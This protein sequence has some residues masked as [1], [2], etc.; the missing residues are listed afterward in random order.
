MKPPY[1]HAEHGEG[2]YAKCMARMNTSVMGPT[3]LYDVDYKENLGYHFICVACD[4]VVQDEYS[5]HI[6]SRNRKQH[7]RW[8]EQVAGSYKH[9]R[10][11]QHL[12]EN[13]MEVHTM[14]PK[15]IDDARLWKRDFH[16]DEIV[17]CKVCKLSMQAEDIDKHVQSASHLANRKTKGPEIV[18]RLWYDNGYECTCRMMNRPHLEFLHDAIPAQ[19]QT[20]NV[21]S[22]FDTDDEDEMKK[23]E[24]LADT[25]RTIQNNKNR[26]GPRSTIA[27][28][29][30]R[31]VFEGV[32]VRGGA[33]RF[34]VCIVSGPVCPLRSPLSNIY[35]VL[36]RH[37]SV[38][39]ISSVVIGIT[40][41]ESKEAPRRFQGGK[42]PLSDLPYEVLR[43]TF[44]KAKF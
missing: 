2:E 34:S 13:F 14:I 6:S 32:L 28:P 16:N 12:R 5:P 33:C 4:K 27:G 20:G 18:Q 7:V 10:H 22:D 37:P 23:L 17:E 38:S 25:R 9:R 19:W 41:R 21:E 39:P 1:G 29:S 11:I 35:H 30:A 44:R 24:E 42:C 40:G 36:D 26:A 15:G 43:S 31:H 3:S 8:M